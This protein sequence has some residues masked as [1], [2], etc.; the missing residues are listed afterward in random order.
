M[1]DEHLSSIGAMVQ[2]ERDIY[3]QQ[4]IGLGLIIS[5]KVV[6]L[7]DG[8]FTIESTV[9]KGTKITFTLPYSKLNE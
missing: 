7:H 8:K 9:G 4:G 3:E 5:R 6:E 2:F 1:S